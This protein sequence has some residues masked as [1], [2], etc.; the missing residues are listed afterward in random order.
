MIH[1]TFTS[2][3][4]EDTNRL[5]R[6]LASAL[7]E[8]VVVGLTGPLGAGKTRLVQA[9][10]QGRGIAREDVTSPTFVL[11]QHYG[12][13]RTIHHFDV[14]RL[15]DDDEFLALGPDEYFESTGVTFVEWA[16]RVETLLPADRLMIH[17][18]V[19]AQHVRRFEIVAMGA[20]LCAVPQMVAQFLGAR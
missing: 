17:I 3:S 13:A 16:D 14:Y 10:A 7:P 11:L 4:E 2:Q 18:T 19:E 1:L 20:A 12:A 9:F 6:A 15:V 8:G 5:G